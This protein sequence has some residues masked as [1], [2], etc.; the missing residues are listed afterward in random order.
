MAVSSHVALNKIDAGGMRELKE[1]MTHM[2]DPCNERLEAVAMPTGLHF[3]V[4]D[5]IFLGTNQPNFSCPIRLLVTD[6]TAETEIC[7]PV[8]TEGSMRSKVNRKAKVGVKKRSAIRLDD[9]RVVA[10]KKASS[11]YLF[12]LR[13]HQVTKKDV[14]Q[15]ACKRWL[16]D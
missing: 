13:S 2:L 14:D 3:V 7:Q 1:C 9:C 8:W 10:H 15:D 5:K 6:Q 16:M 12:F 4:A 11:G